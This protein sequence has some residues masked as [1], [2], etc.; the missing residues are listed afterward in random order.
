M[1]N[2]IAQINLAPSGGYKGFGALGLEQG[3]DAPNVFA[4]F[5]SSTIG[6]ITLIGIIWFVF[7]FLSGAIGIITSGGDKNANE[8]AKKRIS[9]GIIGLTI[10]VFGILVIR[11]IGSLIGFNDIL[12]FSTMFQTL[13]IK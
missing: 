7:I 5:I 6:L 10:T 12:D 2:K 1:I 9:S 11:L 13:I 3:Q 4:T 8:T